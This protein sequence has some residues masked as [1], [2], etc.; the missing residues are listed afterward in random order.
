MADIRVRIVRTSIPQ[1]RER[2]LTIGS[3]GVFAD[4]GLN[5][6]LRVTVETFDVNLDE[7]WRMLEWESDRV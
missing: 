1:L 7:A 3:Y 6:H 4:Y 5:N 2:C